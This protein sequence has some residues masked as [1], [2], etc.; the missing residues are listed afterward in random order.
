MVDQVV[1]YV[2]PAAFSLLPAGLRSLEASAL[3]TAIG[4][5][6]SRFLERHQRPQGPAKGFWQFER[7]GLRATLSHH[8]TREL[9][10]CVI[11]QLRYREPAFSTLHQALEHNDVLAA[12][13]ARLLLWADPL[14]LPGPEAPDTAWAIYLRCWQPGR[15]HPTTWK[16]LYKEAWDRVL[17]HAQPAPRKASS[18]AGR[19]DRRSASGVPP[20]R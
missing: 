6:E 8:R 4:L 9:A 16:G 19:F 1:R 17:L 5:Q 15:P 2:I 13:M 20:A 3:L 14:T 12:A 7:A 10:L 11:S 18:D